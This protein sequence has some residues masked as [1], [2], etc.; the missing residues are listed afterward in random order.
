MDVVKIPQSPNQSSTSN[1]C[2]HPSS[3]QDICCSRLGGSRRIGSDIGT[4][5]AIAYGQWTSLT[6]LPTR[7]NLFTCFIL[8]Y[9]HD[10]RSIGPSISIRPSSSAVHA[11]GGYHMSSRSCRPG[12]AG[13]ALG[14]RLEHLSLL[15]LVCV[16]TKK[17]CCANGCR[18][19]V[20]I[21][22]HVFMDNVGSKENSWR[23]RKTRD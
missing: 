19:Q 6:I 9:S 10:I 14:L 15:C 7:V 2:S 18:L 1:S 3:E 5:R 16:S 12:G 17:P 13:L 21:D 23:K 8:F 20:I 22:V 4:E 11:E